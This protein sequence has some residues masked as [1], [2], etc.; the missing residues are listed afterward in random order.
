M[1]RACR[2]K[3]SLLSTRFVLHVFPSLARVR[4]RSMCP[5]D[6]GTYRPRASGLR[7]DVVS[8]ASSLASSVRRLT[9]NAAWPV[10]A[11][12]RTT[13]LLPAQVSCCIYW[14]RRSRQFVRSFMPGMWDA[15]SVRMRVVHR[16]A[17][18]LRRYAMHP[19]LDPPRRVQTDSPCTRCHYIH[20]PGI[21][22]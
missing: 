17:F 22:K 2:R 4:P 12:H 8:K 18:K 6:V 11:W 9:D 13:S 5:D 19:N 1:V 7:R 3:C 16:S 14:S 10:N 15:A 20:E 21:R